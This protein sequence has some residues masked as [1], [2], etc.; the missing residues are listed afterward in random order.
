MA[1]SFVGISSL[2][3]WYHL[4]AFT[5]PERMNIVMLLQSFRQ[6]KYISL[7]GTSGISGSFLRFVSFE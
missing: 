2:C 7:L 6:L 5:K 3:V 4:Y 1:S